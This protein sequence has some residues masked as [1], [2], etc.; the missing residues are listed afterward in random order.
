MAFADLRARLL[1]RRIASGSST[2]AESAEM[3]AVALVRELAA[4]ACLR[5]G[6]SVSQCLALSEL[7]KLVGYLELTP[8]EDEASRA[9]GSDGGQ[10][11]MGIL[12]TRLLS[13][14]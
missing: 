9:A 11:K 14:T 5:H 12:E 10:W 7:V 1:W 2:G 8:F 6:V 3:S 13:P 4:G